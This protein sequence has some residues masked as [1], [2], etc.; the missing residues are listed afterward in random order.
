MREWLQIANVA[1]PQAQKVCGFQA[2]FLADFET[3]QA[4]MQGAAAADDFDLIYDNK[5][6]MVYQYVNRLHAG[7]IQTYDIK[8]IG[9][10]VGYE[11][12]LVVQGLIAVNREDQIQYQ[13]KQAKRMLIQ[14]MKDIWG[15]DLQKKGAEHV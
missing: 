13:V 10:L 4:V 15:V 6:V 14:A 2:P 5:E 11:S 1:N 12:W 7:R 8:F 9:D 3:I